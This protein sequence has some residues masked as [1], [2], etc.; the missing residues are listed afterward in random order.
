MLHAAVW[1]GICFKVCVAGRYYALFR[2]ARKAS[3]K[4]RPHACGEQA[5]KRADIKPRPALPCHA[6]AP[7]TPAL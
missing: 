1:H 7:S 6:P 4:G 3:W 2:S 5:K